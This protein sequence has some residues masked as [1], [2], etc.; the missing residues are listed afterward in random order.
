ME[1]DLFYF[2]EGKG[3]ILHTTE[4]VLRFFL[5]H[6][7]KYVKKFICF[8]KELLIQFL[9][10]EYDVSLSVKSVSAL[11][12]EIQN[13]RCHLTLRH[14]DVLSSRSLCLIQY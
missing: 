2:K 10:T 7:G 11:Y 13:S 1:E 6:N 3:V 12:N 9:K 4:C 5:C 14:C 8:Q